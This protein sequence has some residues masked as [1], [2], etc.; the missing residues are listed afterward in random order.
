VYRFRLAGEAAADVQTLHE[1]GLEAHLEV[2]RLSRQVLLVVPESQAPRAYELLGISEPAPD[3]SAEADT[4]SVARCP[5]CGSDNSYRLPPYAF[6]V[7]V[8]ALVLF[9]VGLVLGYGR[10]TAAV[11]ALPAWLVATWLSRHSGHYRCRSCGREW[12]P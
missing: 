11:V 5:D 1:A 3:P 2:P 8:G 10:I 12:K 7:L 9:L 6:R 4:F